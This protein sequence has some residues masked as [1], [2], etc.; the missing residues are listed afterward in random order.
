MV[1]VNQAIIRKNAKTGETNP[2]LTVKMGKTNRYAHQ[3]EIL[4]PCTVVYRPHRPLSCGA[5]CWV[6]TQAEVK[7]IQEVTL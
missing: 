2:V 1:H 6:E 5:R 3:V 4:G 7:L